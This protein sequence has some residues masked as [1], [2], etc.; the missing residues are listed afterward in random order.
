[1]RKYGVES[2]VVDTI[3]EG[4]PEY[5]IYLENKLRPSPRIGYN[6]AIGGEATGKQRIVSEET[7]NKISASLTGR[8]HTEEQRAF[9]S[10]YQ[11]G[12]K[13]P[14]GFGE[15]VRERQLG[16]KLNDEWRA[17]ISKAK[18]ETS[19]KMWESR[20]ANKSVWCLADKAYENF[21]VKS[22]R[23]TEKYFGLSKNQLNYMFKAFKSGWIPQEDTAWLQFKEQYLMEQTSEQT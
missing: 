15:K 14:E 22:L 18:K 16:R 12:R 23:E 8:K 9:K 20:S 10:Q 11:K 19:A 17:N 13:Q 3:V 4:S 6:V 2:F 21:L 1:M 7:R 5:I